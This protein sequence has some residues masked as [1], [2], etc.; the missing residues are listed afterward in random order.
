MVHGGHA[1]QAVKVA[2]VGNSYIG[3]LTLSFLISDVLVTAGNSLFSSIIWLG[4]FLL[5]R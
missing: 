1:Q 5:L 4:L 2:H 3:V